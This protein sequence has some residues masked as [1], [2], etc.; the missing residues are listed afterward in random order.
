M[1]RLIPLVVMFALVGCDQT[2]TEEPDAGENLAVTG[3]I[4]KYG[5]YELIRPGTL[6]DVPGTTTGKSIVK[7]VIQLTEQTSRI[8]LKIG[9][10]FAYQYRLRNFPA[11]PPLVQLRRVLKHPEMTLPDGTT[12]TGSD[13][14][15]PG[16][17][18]VGE[19]IGSDGYAFSEDYELAEGEWSFEIWYQG[20]L[21]IEQRFTTYWPQQE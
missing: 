14:M 8:P 2:A 15:I 11:Q 12:T 4:I 9:T 6:R 13:F 17:V 20:K 3:S 1:K 5:I 18:H 7:P 19:V 16:K 10:Y 21:L